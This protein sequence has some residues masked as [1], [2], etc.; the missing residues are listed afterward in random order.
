MLTLLGTQPYEACNGIARRG[1]LRLGTLGAAGLSLADIL[2]LRAQGAGPAGVAPKSV[3]MVYLFGGPSHID[4]YDLK[5]NA[6]AEC[7]G[8]FKPI[9]TAVPGMDICELMPHQAKIADKLTLIRSMKFRDVADGHNPPELLSG[10]VDMNQRPTIGSVVSRLRSDAKMAASMPPYVVL[11]QAWDG[12]PVRRNLAIEGT[13]YLGP[14]HRP[15]IPDAN[16]DSLKLARG[17][18]P[19]QVQDRRMLLRSFDTLRRELDDFH[20]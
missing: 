13:A 11:G 16:L 17:V 6:P 14:A 4:M 7:R 3:I 12:R 2:R 1:F 20:G 10:F 5:P 9:Q 19:E 15:F 8:Q 18:T